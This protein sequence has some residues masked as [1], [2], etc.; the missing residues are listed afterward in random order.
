MIRQI[1]HKISLSTK[2]YINWYG[3]LQMVLGAVDLKTAKHAVRQ[4]GS[5]AFR[6][7]FLYPYAYQ[8][9]YPCTIPCTI[10]YLEIIYTETRV[11]NICSSL[12][13]ETRVNNICSSLYVETRVN[14][15]RSSL[16]VETRVNNICSSLSSFY[17]LYP[18][19]LSPL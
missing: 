12:Y 16:Y 10:L 4:G 9:R 19:F 17:T 7:I 6:T 18:L 1:Q 15:I 2:W 8:S 13:V 14:N 5:G 3:V 11:N